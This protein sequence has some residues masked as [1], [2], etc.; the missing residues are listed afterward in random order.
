MRP[1]PWRS[2]EAK[3]VRPSARD[4]RSPAR[5]LSHTG[6][7]LLSR[8]RAGALFVAGIQSPPALILLLDGAHGE[9]GDE[10]VEEEIVEDGERHA[11]DEAGGHERAP[12]VDVA[13]YQG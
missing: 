8:N 3:R 11:G 7:R 1:S 6:A 9:T 13:P 5:T 10:A 12:V 4:S 2:S